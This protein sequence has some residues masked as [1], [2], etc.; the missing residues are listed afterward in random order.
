MIPCK[1]CLTLPVCKNK[2]YRKLIQDCSVIQKLLYKV[3]Y[4]DSS[5]RRADFNVNLV[6]IEKLFGAEYSPSLMTKD[7]REKAYR[8]MKLNVSMQRLFNNTHM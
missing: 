8:R 4:T 7:Q 6:R 5:T 1:D 2:H 3:K